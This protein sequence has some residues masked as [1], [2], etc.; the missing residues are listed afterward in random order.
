MKGYLFHYKNLEILQLCVCVCVRMCVC[1]FMFASVR[2][3]MCFNFDYFEVVLGLEPRDLL[4]ISKC[5]SR[6]LVL[7]NTFTI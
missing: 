2:V 3:C 7:I 5:N 1:V 4:I 6:Q